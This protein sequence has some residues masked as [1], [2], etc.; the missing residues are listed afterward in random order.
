MAIDGDDDDKDD[1]G[2]AD[3]D[4][5]GGHPFTSS[6]GRAAR[7]QTE[8]LDRLHS[9]PPLPRQGRIDAQYQTVL[10]FPQEAFEPETH[11]PDYLQQEEFSCSVSP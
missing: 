11:P 10:R 1:D 8:R 2:D 5:G 6:R 7:H 4:G 3:G 9:T